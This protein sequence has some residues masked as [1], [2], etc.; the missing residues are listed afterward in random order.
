[1]Y[2][3]EESS[4]SF[5][6]IGSMRAKPGLRAEVISILVSGTD[7]LREVGCIYYLVGADENDDDMIWVSEVW[8]SKEAHAA[9]LELPGTKAAISK[10]MPMLTGEFSGQEVA[11]VG[12]LGA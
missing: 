10:A 2:G 5:G 7:R 4:M 8:T 3:P 11:I 6:Y 1:M 9:S 12:G